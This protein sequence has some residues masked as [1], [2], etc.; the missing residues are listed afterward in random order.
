MADLETLR[1]RLALLKE[2]LASPTHSVREGE[3]EMT[4]RSVADIRK[5]IADIEAEIAAAEGRPAG[6]IVHLRNTRG[7]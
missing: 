3:R 2:D 1:Q 4:A 7:W 6:K 5:A